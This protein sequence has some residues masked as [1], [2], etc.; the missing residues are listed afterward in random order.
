MK[1]VSRHPPLS[2]ERNPHLRCPP[3]R[4]ACGCNF[5]SRAAGAPDRVPCH[6]LVL[7]Q[8]PLAHL[9]AAHAPAANRL[10]PA[11]LTSV[12]GP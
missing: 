7:R 2:L 9:H 10:A 3:P 4:L 1:R 8:P 5:P 12:L 11:P 6:L